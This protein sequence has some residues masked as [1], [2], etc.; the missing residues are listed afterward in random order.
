MDEATNRRRE[1]KEE[2]ERRADE[3]APRILRLSR[4]LHR[5]PELGG[6][7]TRAAMRLAGEMEEAGFEVE[8]GTAGLATAFTARYRSG[9]SGPRIAF[10]AEYDALPELGHACGHNLIAAA[11]FGAATVTASLLHRTG[12]EVVL[13]GTPAEETV[14]GKV[15]MAEKGVFDEADAALMVH[16]GG[17]DRVDTHSLACQSVE[18]EFTGKAAH[19]VA[20]PEKGINALDALIQLFVSLDALKKSLRPEVKMPGY[21]VHGGVRQ[22]IVPD[23]VVAR[24][25]LRAA[26]T[27]YLVE[28]V[29]ARFRETVAG[30]AAATRT[31]WSVRPIDNLYDEMRTN[32]ALAAAYRRNLESRGVRVV[33]GER[34]AMGSLDMGNVSQRV[35]SVHPFFS[36]VPPEVASHT[37]EFARAAASESG[38]EGLRRSVL[39]LASTAVDLLGDPG[40]LEE[41]REE[42]RA[43]LR[44]R[45]E[46][47]GGRPPRRRELILE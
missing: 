26:D 15:I 30:I 44:E 20:H 32:R 24:F 13:Y 3:Q 17:E 36:I 21:I 27:D 39:A 10:L 25:S 28:T 5:D 47:R 16:P 22:N 1:L 9:R 46:R 6:S 29:Q 33:E 40:L 12:G 11:A 4:D 14:G 43:F 7:E 18:V 42:H 2:V 23:R 37:E 34:E 41:I 45:E 35:P 31:G 8:T 19:A 38:E